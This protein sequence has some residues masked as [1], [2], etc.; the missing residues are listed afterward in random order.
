[1]LPKLSARREFSIAAGANTACSDA[2]YNGCQLL[3][4]ESWPL[5]TLRTSGSP[6]L[7]GFPQHG[8]TA[9]RVGSDSEKQ[10]SRNARAHAI[11]KSRDRLYS[12]T[13]AGQTQILT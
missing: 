13:S 1:M 12:G 3:K 8:R 6:G 9:R 5:Y 7:V 10:R 11:S 2:H 4:A